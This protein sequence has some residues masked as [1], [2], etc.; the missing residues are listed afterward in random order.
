MRR[1][2]FPLLL[3]LSGVAV[4]L[5]LGIWQV[6]RL[7]WKRDILAGIEARL[8]ADPVALPVAPTEE[9]DEYRVVTLTGMP[10][11]PELHV[12]TS[13]TAA[14]TGYRVISGFDTA[15]GRRVLV[16]L[17][18]LPLEMKDDPA[19][20]YVDKRINVVGSLLWPDDANSATPEPDLGKNIWFARD[21]AAMSEVLGSEPTLV[22]LSQSSQPDARL[23]ALPVDTS[24][25]KND[26][27]EYAIT[28][29][30]LALVWA[31][32]SGYLIVRTLR[33]ERAEKGK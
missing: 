16:D 13:G 29:F 23:T 26:H 6:Q 12:L 20:V 11:G 32:M 27:R 17:G 22:V 14:G 24:N 4:L 19:P 28:W 5:S 33:G 3:G 2:I 30:L 7:D 15:D 25:I 31:A 1:L 21:V 8:A 18:L 10:Q 9:Q